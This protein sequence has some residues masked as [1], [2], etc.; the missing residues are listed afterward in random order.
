MTVLISVDV[1]F[2]VMVDSFSEDGVDIIKVVGVDLGALA[3][4]VI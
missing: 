1:I 2:D 3:V 4:T